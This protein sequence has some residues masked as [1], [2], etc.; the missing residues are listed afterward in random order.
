M[1]RAGTLLELARSIAGPGEPMI[2]ATEYPDGPAVVVQTA[3]R[4]LFARVVPD[5][6]R[7]GS[8]PGVAGIVAVTREDIDHA[9]ERLFLL[10][11]DETPLDLD[12]Q[13]AV[14]DLG[15]AL[16]EPWLEP[17][18]F[19][20]ILVQRHWPAPGPREVITDPEAWAGSLSVGP[21]GPPP[22][23]APRFWDD[24]RGDRWLAFY[25]ARRDPT[26]PDPDTALDVTLWSVRV[27]PAGPVTWLRR[28]A[29]YA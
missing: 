19:A 4:I 24:E 10:F 17:L 20:E 16:R 6:L 26:A 14:A 28:P 2:S 29:A 18:A 7:I 3:E 27:P 1:V 8:A 5:R 22:V 13:R 11:D 25:A 15:R 21:P 23:Q 12:D 9:G